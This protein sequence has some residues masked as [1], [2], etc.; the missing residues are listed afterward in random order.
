[1]HLSIGADEAVWPDDR[2]AVVERVAR[3]LADAGND[4]GAVPAGRFQPSL[5]RRPIR[6]RLAPRGKP[7]APTTAPGRRAAPSQASDVGPLGTGSASVKASC[8]DA[9]T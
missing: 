8:R 9:K 2:G 7:L 6:H 3:S 1:M 5:R 4:H